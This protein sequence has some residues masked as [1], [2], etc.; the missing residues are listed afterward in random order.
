MK[1][2]ETVREIAEE[3]LG[4]EGEGRNHINFVLPCPLCKEVREFAEYADSKLQQQKDSLIKKVEEMKEIAKTAR[5]FINR[6]RYNEACD[7]FISLIKNH[8]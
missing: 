3:F 1:T 5:Q 4:K 7:D 6:S 2:N 8:E